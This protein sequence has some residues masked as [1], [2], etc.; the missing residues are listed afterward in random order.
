MKQFVSTD[1]FTKPLCQCC[2]DPQFVFIY[3][4][5]RTEVSKQQHEIAMKVMSHTPHQHKG[6]F[7]LEER[8]FLSQKRA[9][10]T[11]KW[12]PYLPDNL[13]IRI[14][15]Y[16]DNN[17]LPKQLVALKAT[18]RLLNNFLKKYFKYTMNRNDNSC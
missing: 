7:I 15:N 10:N 14:Y 3:S 5:F 11:K 16:G 9:S 12:M 18:S 1:L 4:V 6:C 17:Q 2:A 8:L 13:V